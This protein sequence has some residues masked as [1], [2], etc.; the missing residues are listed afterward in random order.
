MKLLRKWFGVS[1]RDRGNVKFG[2]KHIFLGRA[3]PEC[4]RTILP[5]AALADPL[6]PRYKR[7]RKAPA[8][9]SGLLS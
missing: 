9:T 2:A 7:P 3:R 8:G 5:G 4:L 6:L 1:Y